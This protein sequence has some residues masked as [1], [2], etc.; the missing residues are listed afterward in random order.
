VNRAVFC[1]SDRFAKRTRQAVLRPGKEL[2]RPGICYL[3]NSELF[4]IDKG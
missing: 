3:N 1:H 2:A 4:N